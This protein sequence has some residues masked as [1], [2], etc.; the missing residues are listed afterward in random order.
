MASN[1]IR[2]DQGHF[3]KEFSGV[4]KFR[5][6]RI[7]NGKDYYGQQQLRTTVHNQLCIVEN[8]EERGIMLPYSM[9]FGYRSFTTG[10]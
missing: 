1:F 5:T 7:F 9:K 8:Y 10:P 3:S 4:S 6:T 2:A